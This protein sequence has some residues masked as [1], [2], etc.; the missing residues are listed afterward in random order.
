[1]EQN[2]TNQ[3]DAESKPNGAV[4]PKP[5]L[6]WGLCKSDCPY[7]AKWEHP[8]WHH[9]A[10]CWHLMKNLS[11]YDYWQAECLTTVPNEELVKIRNYGRTLAPNVEAAQLNLLKSDLVT[12]H[13]V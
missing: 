10:W 2:L 13:P 3:Q 7:L 5:D 6:E 1:M 12:K 8:F 11:F 9:T 4:P